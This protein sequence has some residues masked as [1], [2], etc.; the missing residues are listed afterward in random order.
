MS[1][2][3]AELFEAYDEKRSIDH[4]SFNEMSAMLES[5]TEFV[6]EEV[7]YSVPVSIEELSEGVIYEADKKFG[8][9]LKNAVSK[10]VEK[11]QAFISKIGE[12]LKRFIAKAKLT[13]AQGGNAAISKIIKS[14]GA[15]IGKDITLIKPKKKDVV[16]KGFAAALS[17]CASVHS[18]LNKNTNVVLNAPSNDGK[19][20]LDEIHSQLRLDAGDQK[21]VDAAIKTLGKGFETSDVVEKYKVRAAEKKAVKDVYAEYV[22]TWNDLVSKN[23]PAIDSSCKDAQK[24]AKNLIKM[25]SGIKDSDSPK[26]M[27]AKKML[28]DVSALSTKMMQLSTYTLNFAFKVLSMS[29]KNAAKI[30]V[31]AVGPTGKALASGAKGDVKS[32]ASDAKYAVDKAA[33]DNKSA[34][35]SA[36]AF[37]ATKKEDQ[38][39]QK[40]SDVVRD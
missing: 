17:A 32:K 2:D 6:N 27:T 16:E 1:N 11:L 33:N 34:K 22:K 36:S 9:G 5:L 40:R 4:I 37:G 19:V 21:L 39:V 12:A 31:A 26:A 15:I 18:V 25:F 13:I 8:E 35:A 28:A 29:T 20:E 24:T 7:D 30:A 10:F 3:F 23:V 38:K 14:N